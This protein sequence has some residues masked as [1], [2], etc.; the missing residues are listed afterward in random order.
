MFPSFP[1]PEK[2]SPIVGIAA[3]SNRQTCGVHH[4]GCGNELLFARPACG[5]GILLHLWKMGPDMLAA[6]LFSTMAAMD[7]RWDSHPK[8]IQLVLVETF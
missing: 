4:F 3:T 8:S 2:G 5:C 6:L 1:P 7:V